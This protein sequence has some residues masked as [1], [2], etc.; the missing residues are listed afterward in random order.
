MA[1][2]I[3]TIH[4]QEHIKE[5]IK[6]SQLVNRLRNHVLGKIDLSATQ[7]Q[8]A[9]ALLRKV[10]PD[11]ASSEVKVQIETVSDTLKEISERKQKL[12]LE[13]AAVIPPAAVH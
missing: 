8:A 4:I 9:T 10:V 12:S 11:I 7:V 5:K 2:R 3:N 1:K 13:Q 6:A